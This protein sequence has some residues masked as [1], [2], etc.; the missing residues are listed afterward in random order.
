MTTI[1][2]QLSL[3]DW[4]RRH[5][6]I[7]AGC[8][9]LDD[10]GAGHWPE[11]CAEELEEYRRYFEAE[12]RNAGPAGQR[13]YYTIREAAKDSWRLFYAEDYRGPVMQGRV[14][15]WFDA[16]GDLTCR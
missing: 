9:G 13:A 16:P 10:P 1:E 2:E 4:L 3:M 11:Q 14:R 12:L 8:V 15:A 6:G 7:G 5:S